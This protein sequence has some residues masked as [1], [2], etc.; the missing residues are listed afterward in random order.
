MHLCSPPI[1]NSLTIAVSFCILTMSA[2]IAQAQT[3]AQTQALTQASSGRVLQVQGDVRIDGAAARS[4]QAIAGGTVS[5][6]ADSR[7][8]LRL[9]DGTL[10]ALPPASEIS[11]AASPARRL[12]LARGGLRL[13]ATA[14]L[15]W[16]VDLPGR[17][18]RT[19]GFLKLQECSAGC[20]LPA[21]FYGRISS[22]EAVLEYQGS[23]SVLRNRASAGPTAPPALSYCP[24]SPHCW[25]T[26]KTW[27]TPRRP[28]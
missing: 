14:D 1:N 7:A 9:A 26:P 12:S 8:Q 21:G 13:N 24:A 2:G 17:S 18:I 19:S 22:G 5:T 28:G 27:P 6:G 15:P 3:Q 10:I 25:T 20:T 16:Q 23:R 4:G 11:L